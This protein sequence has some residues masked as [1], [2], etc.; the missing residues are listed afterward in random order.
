M[1]LIGRAPV[2]SVTQSISSGLAMPPLTL[3]PPT[4]PQ[5]QCVTLTKILRHAGSSLY[6][7]SAAAGFG[8]RALL[9]IIARAHEGGGTGKPDSQSLVYMDPCLLSAS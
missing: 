7:V 3:E 2:A 8:A 1:K 6:V 5:G 4:T 9:R